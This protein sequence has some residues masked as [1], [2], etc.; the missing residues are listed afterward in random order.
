[1]NTCPVWG[2]HTVGRGDCGS[3]LASVVDT[4]DTFSTLPEKKGHAE[5][6]A[7]TASF[8]LS[9]SPVPLSLQVPSS[10][11]SGLAREQNYFGPTPTSRET[12]AMSQSL[13]V[14][15]H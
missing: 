4:G 3:L 2:W 13:Q 9:F 15:I 7:G 11:Q 6:N 12:L 8:Y 10:S 5:V 1:M 14:S